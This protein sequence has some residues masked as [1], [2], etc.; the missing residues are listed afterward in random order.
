MSPSGNWGRGTDGQ[1]VTEDSTVVYEFDRGMD[2]VI[3][4]SVSTYRGREYLD[5]RTWMVIDGELRPTKK[6][7][8]VPTDFLPELE[9]A[10]A[11]LRASVDPDGIHAPPRTVAGAGRVA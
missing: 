4:A 6:G 8:S 5:L 10:V 2:R 7:V 9:Q 11:A 3:R 1:S